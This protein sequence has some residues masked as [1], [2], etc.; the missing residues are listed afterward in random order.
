VKEWELIITSVCGV[1]CVVRFMCVWCVCGVCG[2]G[3]S[4]MGLRCLPGSGCD[5]N[6]YIENTG[7]SFKY[8]Y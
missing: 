5:N 6:V 2:C 8:I 7:D 4:Y 1:V 3:W